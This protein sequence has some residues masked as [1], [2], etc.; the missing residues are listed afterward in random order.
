[1]GGTKK[2]QLKAK[3]KNKLKKRALLVTRV[4]DDLMTE[5]G[6]RELGDRACETS[7]EE[8]ERKSKG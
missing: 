5:I 3:G 2:N 1:M 7:V 4:R 8:P 6:T